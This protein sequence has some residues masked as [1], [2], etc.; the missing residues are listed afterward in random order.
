MSELSPNQLWVEIMARPRP[1]RVVDFPRIN[2]ITGKTFGEIAIMVLTQEEQMACAASAERFT[3]QLLKESPKADDAKRGYDDIFQNSASTEIL[4]RACKRKEDLTSPFFPSAEAIRRNLSLDEVSVLMNHYFSAQHEMGPIVAHISVE[5][6]EAWIK[7]LG[8]GGSSFPLDFLSWEALKSLAFSLA[9]L[10]HRSS[11]SRS[12]LG[13]QHED[14][15]TLATDS[16]E[17]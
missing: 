15:Q 9:C 4:F 2:P 1:H 5:E 12:S 3:K 7:R 13:L 10:L 17:A 6:V 14:P 16:S 8:E 11:T